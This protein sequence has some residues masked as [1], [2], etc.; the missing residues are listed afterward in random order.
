[1]QKAESETEQRSKA[2]NT[3]PREVQGRRTCMHWLSSARTDN[4]PATEVGRR[5]GGRMESV[6][7]PVDG[8]GDGASCGGE[9]AAGNQR[10]AS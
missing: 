7:G 6:G 5:H 2:C 4:D 9:P 8:A 1:M 3:Q 10:E